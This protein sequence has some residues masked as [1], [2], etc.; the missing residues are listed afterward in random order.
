M[1]GRAGRVHPRITLATA[2]STPRNAAIDAYRGIAVLVMAVG[3]LGLGVRWVPAALKHATDIGFTI[4]DVVAPMFMLSIALVVGLRVEDWRAAPDKRPI[5]GRMA[6]RGLMLLGLGALISGGQAL[7]EVVGP[8]AL[9]WGVLQAIG[10]ATLLLL[11]VV[12]LPAWARWA[13]G[14]VCLSVYQVLLDRFFLA[15]VLQISFD[16]ILGTL[17]WGGFLMIAS[18]VA[19]QWH[20]TQGAMRRT[21]LLAGVGTASALLAWGL[22]GW[23]PV[24]KNRASFTYEL[25][26]LGLCLLLFAIVAAILDD[27]PRRW[28]W[29]QSPGRHPLP[30]YFAHLITMAFLTLPGADGWYAGAPVWLTLLQAAVMVGV[31]LT[32]AAVLDRRGWSL[33]L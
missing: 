25:L 3:N 16:S 26:A 11:P 5:R 17:A 27:R 13:A 30:L 6:R 20:R 15:A 28:R 18:A 10:A 4:A 7:T 23:I 31:L 24:S 33:R 21:V 19:E 32:V 14:L 29:L 22:S 2:S 1:H 8:T 12:L 9:S